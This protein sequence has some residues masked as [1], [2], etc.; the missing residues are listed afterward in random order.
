[1]R[2]DDLPGGAEYVMEGRV[3]RCPWHQWEFDITTGR[4]LARPERRIRTYPVHI[5]DG[6]VVLTR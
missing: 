3:L 6:H 5:S 4:T 2:R 1:M